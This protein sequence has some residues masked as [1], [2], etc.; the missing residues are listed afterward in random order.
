VSRLGGAR[1]AGVLE[2]KTVFRE[3]V[4]SLGVVREVGVLVRVLGNGWSEGK[5]KLRTV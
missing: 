1:V 5:R 4:A 2:R 3:R